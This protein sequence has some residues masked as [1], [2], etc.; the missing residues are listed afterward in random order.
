MTDHIAA[1]TADG[2][3][4]YCDYLIGKG[5]AP[6]S[7][8]N[9]WKSAVKQVFSTVEDGDDYGALDVKGLNLDEYMSRFETKV[10]G[11]LKQESVTAYRQRVKKALDSYREYLDNPNG[12][13][14]PSVRQA[15]RRAPNGKATAPKGTGNGKAAKG[16]GQAPDANGSSLIDYPFPL[17][18]G[19]IAHVRLPA[20]LE[21]GDADRLATFVRTLVFE[22]VL[23]LSEKAGSEAE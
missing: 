6:P 19:Q 11:K 5:Y 17:Q 4:E 8:V 23:E 14:P 16:N 7:A 20:K 1:G 12:W 18:S 2:L 13:Q 15:A 3:I 9:P 21:K 22:P 10:R